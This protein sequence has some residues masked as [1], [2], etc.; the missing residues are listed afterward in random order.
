VPTRA[1]ISLQKNSIAFHT[2]KSRRTAWMLVLKRAF[3]GELVVHIS[4]MYCSLI[5]YRYTG[6]VGTGD[7]KCSMCRTAW[8]SA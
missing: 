4:A 8:V 2:K 5:K 7:P 1:W 6:S 3:A